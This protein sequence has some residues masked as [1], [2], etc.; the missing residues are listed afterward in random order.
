MRNSS[1]LQDRSWWRKC[2]SDLDALT[3]SFMIAIHP[4]GKDTVTTDP[5]T[6]QF[7]GLHVDS[8]DRLPIADRRNASNRICVNVGHSPRYF[9]FVNRSLAAIESALGFDQLNVTGANPTEIARSFLCRFPNY[10]VL[11]IQV[12][13]DEAYIAPT[14]NIIHDGSSSESTGCTGH[15]TLR[16]SIDVIDKRIR[17]A[18][19]LTRR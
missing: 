6:R 17:C 1:S 3:Q 2:A 7:I 13:P 16:G 11:R 8:W 10:P 4:R 5:H 14:E 9:L 12:D 15:V 18:Q 19:N